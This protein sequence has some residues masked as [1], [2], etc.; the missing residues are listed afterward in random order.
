MDWQRILRRALSAGLR[1]ASRTLNKRSSEKLREPKPRSKQQRGRQPVPPSQ[2]SN[3]PGDFT[4]R[5]NTVYDAHIDGNPDPGEIV[6]TW[7][8]FEEDYSQ[9]KDR[10]VLLIGRDGPWLIGLQVT[11]KDK[12]QDA[13]YEASQG[14][15]WEDIGSGAWD[16]KGR[17]SEVRLNRFI[18]VDP[19]AVRRVGAVLDEGTFNRIAKL[20][21]KYS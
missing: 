2:S 16:A 9:G 17:P 1:E 21:A 15:Y 7:V 19:E 8:P 4:G 18:R 13:Q 6:W 12:D 5:V 14:R 10:P 20:V 3:Y 11:S